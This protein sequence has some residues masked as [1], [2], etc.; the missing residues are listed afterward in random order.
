MVLN[1]VLADEMRHIGGVVDGSIAMPVY[2][3]V[4]KVLH[5][6]FECRVD[7]SFSLLLLNGRAIFVKCRYL[8]C[9]Y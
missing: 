4:D 3:R 7:E 1:V 8:W 2:R 5:T 9:L 6:V